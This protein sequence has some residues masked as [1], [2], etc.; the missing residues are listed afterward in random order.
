MK[1]ANDNFLRNLKKMEFGARKGDLS[2]FFQDVIIVRH[3]RIINVKNYVTRFHCA[4]KVGV[5]LVNGPC[6]L[7]DIA[8]TFE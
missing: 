7:L 3:F 4:E 6:D 1:N 5:I 8:H 2:F